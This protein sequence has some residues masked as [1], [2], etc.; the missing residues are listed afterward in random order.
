MTASAVILHLPPDNSIRGTVLRMLRMQA[1]PT[2]ELLWHVGA[3]RREAR[4]VLDRLLA[5][6][7]IVREIKNNKVMWSLA[8]V[9]APARAPGT[10]P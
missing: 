9:Q 2:D 10:A 8:E 3:G 6:G 4:P 1:W 5:E 7:R